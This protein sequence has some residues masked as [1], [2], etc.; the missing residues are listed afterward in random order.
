MAIRLVRA[1]ALCGIV[2]GFGASVTTAQSAGRLGGVPAVPAN[3]TIPE[4][5]SLFFKAHAV[6]TQNYVCLPTTTGVAWKFVG[7]QATLFHTFR[8]EATQQVTTHFL[9]AN[10]DENGT[11]RPT[12]QHSFDSSRVWARVLEPSSDPAYV[13][14]GAIP[15]LK[16]QVSGAARGPEGGAFMTRA[17]FIQR[18]NTSGGVAPATG[19]SATAQ[20][21]AMVLVPYSADYYFYRPTPEE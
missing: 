4:G 3:L 9:S 10:P 17:A 7:P 6:G 20:I 8:G 11:L 21:G 5:Y 16:L 1:L 19:C 15:W 14:A 2:L 13:E 18:L 12:W